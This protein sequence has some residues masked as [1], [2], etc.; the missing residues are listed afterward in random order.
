[1]SNKVVNFL[2][3][4]AK[5]FLKRLV[6]GFVFIIAGDIT[7]LA[8][9]VFLKMKPDDYKLYVISLIVALIVSFL[10]IKA[11]RWKLWWPRIT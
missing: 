10:F 11:T 6:V 4:T 1:M 9:Y 8:L 5:V 3:N 7:A 2:K